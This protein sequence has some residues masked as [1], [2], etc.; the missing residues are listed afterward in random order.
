MLPCFLGRDTFC[1][2]PQNFETCIFIDILFCVFVVS[3]RSEMGDWS[4]FF[5]GLGEAVKEFSE[6]QAQKARAQNQSQV[7]VQA[8]VPIASP[9]S[10]PNR[11]YPNLNDVVG[12]DN[13]NTINVLQ[14]VTPQQSARDRRR[15]NQ[16]RA[17]DEE[18]W[19]VLGNRPKN[20]HSVPAPSAANNN[21][22]NGGTFAALGV[23][24]LGLGAYA[25]Y[26]TFFSSDEEQKSFVNTEA[27]CV[28]RLRKLKEDLEEFPVLGL[29]CQWVINYRSQYDPRNPIALLQLATHK[30]NIMIVPMNRFTL[31]SELRSIL[32]NSEIIKTG[33]EVIKDARYLREDHGLEVQSTFDL[34]FIAE[35]TG[36]RP[37]GLEG[38]AKDVLDLDIGHDWEIINSDWSKWPLDRQQIAYAETAV[39]ASIDIFS[40]LYPFTNSGPTKKDVLAYCRPNKDR[41][42]IWDTRR[43]N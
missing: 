35:D 16:Q 33:I 23:A 2:H 20:R 4:K 3:L 43:W 13:G 39:K 32:N 7:N 31:P 14:V 8:E 25:A 36:H 30:G 5:Q 26:K 28:K 34:R 12:D 6:A 37:V 15:R 11:L 21:N 22:G 9:G 10:R 17:D 24:A 27:D 18:D 41:P 42:F 19:E 40:T 1:E 38:L 29:D